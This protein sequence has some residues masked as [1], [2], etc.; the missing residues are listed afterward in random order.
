[1]VTVFLLW[2]SLVLLEFKTVGIATILEVCS[3]FLLLKE[4]PQPFQ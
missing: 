2:F 1:M 3:L 4:K